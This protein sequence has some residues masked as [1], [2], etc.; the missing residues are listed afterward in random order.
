MADDLASDLELLRHDGLDPVGVG[1]RDQ[2]P[3]LGAEHTGLHGSLEQVV[4][5]WDRLHHLG[6]LLLVGEP[7]VDLQER[8]HALLLPEEL[9][10]AD[11][12]DLAVHR[13]LEED[14]ARAPD[15]R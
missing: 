4:Q 13:V 8:H 9:R 3:H 11:A 12:L 6:S 5:P 15:R 10:R 2:R 14:R 7:L 1:P